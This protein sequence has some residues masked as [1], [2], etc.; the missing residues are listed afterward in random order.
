MEKKPCDLVK[1]KIL[2]ALALDHRHHLLTGKWYRLVH[3]RAQAH[4]DSLKG[5]HCGLIR[6]NG[7][8]PP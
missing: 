2:Q 6:I 3:A 4:V 5:C 8:R 7:S 1:E